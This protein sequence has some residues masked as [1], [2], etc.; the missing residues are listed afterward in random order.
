MRSGLWRQAWVPPRDLARWARHACV[1]AALVGCGLA[2]AQTPRDAA[3]RP[4]PTAV[5]LT[6]SGGVSLGAYEAGF[7][8]Y[9]ASSTQGD[10]VM[11][12]RLVTGASAG[13]LNALLAVLAT[14]GVDATSPG[15]SLFWSTWIPVGFDRLFVPESTTALGVFSREWLARGAQDIEQA[16]NR[17]LPR[18]C[19]VVLGVS[20]TR[21][22]PRVLQ[23]AGGR[24]ALP[25]L[26]EKFA[27]RIQGQGPG[28]PPRATN[29]T[30]PDAQ[31]MELML[32]T[33]ADGTIGFPQL[34]D[35][36]FASMAFPIAFP[37]QPLD[38]CV[39]GST[40]TAGVCLPSE[41]REDLFIDGGV[42]DN[43]PLRLA[44]GLA[45]DGLRETPDGHLEWST[46]PR[47]GTRRTPTNIAF[48]F[49]DPDATEYPVPP[50]TPTKAE[51]ASLPATLGEL[52]A[53][54]VDTARSKEL[55][56]LLEEEPEISQRLALPR[57]HFPAASAPLFAFLGFFETEFRVFDFY[58]GMYDARRMLEDAFGAD[59]GRYSHAHTSPKGGIGG[60]RPFAC[61]RAVYD[62][63]GDA[64]RLCQGEDL[65]DFRALLQVSLDQLYSA[66]SAV[67]D[68]P[69]ATTWRNAHCDRAIAGASPPHVPG[70][71]PKRWPDWKRSEKETELDYTMRLLGAYGFHFRD[72]GVA[73]GRGDL[74]ITHI[75]RT[76]G[77][78]LGKLADAQPGSDKATVRFAGKVAADSVTYEPQQVVIHVT[79]GPT[80]SEVGL[81][82][83]LSRLPL[84][85]GLRLASAIDF[86]GLEDIFSA[87]SSDRFGIEVVTGLEFQPQAE[88]S[89][90]A[91]SRLGL[92]GGWLFSSNDHYATQ[93]CEE[94]GARSVTACSR[95]VFQAF[96]GLTFLE[97]FRVQV[98]GEWYPGSTSRKSLWAV[99]PGIGL[100][101]GL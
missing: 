23:A 73:P 28:R 90:L 76:L 68:K 72:L 14:C 70:V 16:W 74:A 21:M 43:T 87:A 26:E 31:R 6:V 85:M 51:T 96:A 36:L 67:G 46:T 86:R 41:A 101:L 81:S 79:M 48:A 30:T 63:T 66:C 35:L 20:T 22:E 84:P 98:V 60:W 18:S 32:V 59:R 45:R 75:R 42:F 94:R 62:S 52:L 8:Y 29:Y 12:L 19:D 93:G 82:L 44:V 13:G 2:A 34:R 15:Q 92:R 37:P 55:A 17:G 24:L 89:I 56:L 7:L 78:A 88:Q 65:A 54:F 25:R 69:Q 49:I 61:M 71:T 100:E 80:Q 3:G 27:I 58:L 99:A 97:R 77:H 39:P 4:A 64:E 38:T 9:A 5:S 95:P 50:S 10:R 11:D 40:A 33:H 47:S 83:G 57:R 53:A 91:Q 1:G